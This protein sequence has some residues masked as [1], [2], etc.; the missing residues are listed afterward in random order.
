[1][2]AEGLTVLLGDLASVGGLLDRQA[3]STTLEV[4]LDDL[5]PQLLAGRDDLLGQVDVVCGH[6]RDVHEAFDAVAH[7]DEGAERH[8]LGDSA[9]HQLTFLVAIG[10]LLPRVGLGVLER[11]ADAL[12][13]EVHVEN[14]D[15]DLVTHG[16]DGRWVLDVLPAQLGHVNESVH[17]SEVHERPEVHDRRDDSLA[18]LTWLEVIEE[19]ASLLLLGLL[20]PCST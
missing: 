12:L 4:D 20:E 5:D 13:V 9:V 19:V 17:P 16:D 18:S 15:L 6:L 8:Q 7:L 3:D 1:M 11:Q 14:L 2:L 10:E